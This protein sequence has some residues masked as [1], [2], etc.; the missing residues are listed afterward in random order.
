MTP[1]AVGCLICENI[2]SALAQNPL[3]ATSGQ[4]KH[5]PY[6]VCSTLEGGEKW[7]M[8][9]RSHVASPQQ[10]PPPLPGLSNVESDL[11]RIRNV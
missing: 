5:G 4:K 1:Y 8:S 10:V 7:A 6:R 3:E 11:L 2:L 9:V